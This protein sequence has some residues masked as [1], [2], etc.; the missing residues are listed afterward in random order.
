MRELSKKVQK[1]SEAEYFIFISEQNAQFFV[2][3]ATNHLQQTDLEG[4]LST[5]V[6]IQCY[7]LTLYVEIL[8]PPIPPDPEKLWLEEG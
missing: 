3:F 7:N 6:N 2:K 5:E 1:F 4:Q 8:N